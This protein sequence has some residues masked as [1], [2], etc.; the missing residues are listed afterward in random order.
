MPIWRQTSR[1]PLNV[2][3]LHD[4]KPIII[5]GLVPCANESSILRCCKQLSIKKFPQVRRNLSWGGQTLECF[6]RG[7]VCFT[8]G[9]S[10]KIHAKFHG[11]TSQKEICLLWAC[12]EVGN[13]DTWVSRW[14]AQL[15]S[16]V[17]WTKGYIY[18]TLG[19]VSTKIFLILYRITHFRATYAMAYVA[20]R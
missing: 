1:S 20:A 12:P 9:Q 15:T 4:A 17:C 5:C 7:Q 18:K 3:R 11:I 13:V 19:F 8:S 10:S 16:A 6:D 2:L 14:T